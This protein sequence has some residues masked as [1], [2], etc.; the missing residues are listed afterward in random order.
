MFTPFAF[1]KQEV[2]GPPAFDYVLGY[3]SSFAAYSIARKLSSTY[4]G[5]A[6]RVTRTYDSATQDIGFVDN[7]LDIASLNSFIGANTGNVTIL[8]DQSGNGVNLT[9]AA[10]IVDTGVLITSSANIPA[11]KF[12]GTDQFFAQTTAFTSNKIAEV[13]SVCTID[14]YTSQGLFWGNPD[15]GYFYGCYE[16]GSGNVS[17]II[18]SGTKLGE[19]A[20]ANGAIV[21]VDSFM[22]VGGGTNASFLW[23]DGSQT[24]FTINDG[25]FSAGSFN[26]INLG[27][28]P[29]GPTFYTNGRV[30]E[31]ILYQNT[32]SQRSSIRTN[33]DNFYN[34]Y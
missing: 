18:S 3:T 1:I 32:D 27:R 25:D 14:A 34:T 24:D 23:I 12:N 19:Q 28:G 9:G 22:N 21:L 30:S 26:K 13:M 33:F 20:T 11:V 17:T 10:L 6:I 5:S 8:Y 29:F 2:A 15:N 7:V 31:W 16:A 4:T